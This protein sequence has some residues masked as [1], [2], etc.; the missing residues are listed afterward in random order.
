MLF[1]SV[2]ADVFTIAENKEKNKLL[3]A[4]SQAQ[5][6]LLANGADT[7]L[8]EFEKVNGNIPTNLFTLESLKPFNFGYLIATWEHRTFLTSQ[9]LQI[10]PFDQYGVS[11][12]KIFT[13]KYLEEHGG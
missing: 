3:Y 13:K 6:N 8:Q 9:M 4:Q 12:G 5:S 1:R 10:N 2:C 7:E 11:A